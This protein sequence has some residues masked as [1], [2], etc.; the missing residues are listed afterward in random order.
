MFGDKLFTVNSGSNTFAA[1]HIPSNNPQHPIL[2]GAAVSTGGDVPNSVAYSS[3]HNLACVTNTGTK[4]GVQCFTISDKKS[5][6]PFGS[7]QPIKLTTPQTLP[8]LGPTNTVSDIAFNPRENFLMATVK[9]DGTNPGYIYVWKVSH[10]GK[11]DAPVISQPK[12]LLV[13]FGFNFIAHKRAVITDPSFGAAFVTIHDDLTV[14][15]DNKVAVPNQA[16]IC[17]SAYSEATSSVFLLDAGAPTIATLDSHT[18]GMKA[19]IPVKTETMG[20]FDGAVAG[21]HLYVLEAASGVSVYDIR[22]KQPKAIQNLNLT[23]LGSRAGWT[24][25]AVY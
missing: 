12:E 3:K 5:L 22:A 11:M 2:I 16:A 14:T 13:N 19:T 24:G 8:P 25:I 17:W 4:S 21:N 10:D 6:K 15:V 7:F 9:G 20:S 1:F 23:S 18:G